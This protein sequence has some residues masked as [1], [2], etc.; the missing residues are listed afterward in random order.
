MVLGAIR[1]TPAKRPHV[2]RLFSLLLALPFFAAAQDLTAPNA[3]HIFYTEIPPHL[4]ATQLNFSAG[5]ARIARGDK[6]LLSYSGE[7][8][9][10][11]QLSGAIYLS[12]G[13]GVTWM[14]SH[15][16]QPQPSEGKPGSVW[17][18]YLPSGL[19][20]TMGNDEASFI[21]GLDLL[22]GY[23]FDAH[24]GLPEP[25]RFAWGIGPEFGFLLRAGPRYTKGLL[26][27]MIGKLQFMQLPD[28]SGGR[29][30]R[31][32]YGGIGL[33]LRFY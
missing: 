3:L 29:G 8:K 28:K 22:P 5:T 15:D 13:A 27:G 17:L 23:Y 10:M 18:A 30:L 24:P 32:T 20:F 16:R 11:Y 21:S 4:F 25:R 33:M 19:G 1:E 2:R 12:S 9:G 26:I 31:Y 14:R 6:A 7:V